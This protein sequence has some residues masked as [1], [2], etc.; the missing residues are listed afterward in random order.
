LNHKLNHSSGNQNTLLRVRFFEKLLQNIIKHLCML[1]ELFIYY[2]AYFWFGFTKSYD[3]REIIQEMFVFVYVY[4]W[5]CWITFDCIKRIVLLPVCLLIMN[6]DKIGRK[7]NQVKL[8]H[9]QTTKYQLYH[10]DKNTAKK[11]DKMRDC[12]LLF[13]SGSN[14]LW[15]RRKEPSFSI[16]NRL[17]HHRTKISKKRE[18]LLG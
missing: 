12:L 6:R 16:I 3:F 1:C 10:I 7:S 9:T 18:Q 5:I 14:L 13:K 17:W 11:T 15:E 2:F 4:V 8:S